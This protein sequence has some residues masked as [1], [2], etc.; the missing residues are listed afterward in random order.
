M[1]IKKD[2][3]YIDLANNLA[4][5][6]LGY[7][8]PNPSV[9]A[10]I[11][12]NNKVLSFGSTNFSGRP[13][14]E[15]NALNKLTFKDKKNSTI[16]IS[17]EPCSHFGKTPPCVNEL[18]NSKVKKVVYSAEDVDER[19]SG[20]AYKILKSSKIEV[21]KNILNN[22]SK[23]IYKNYFYSKIN[24][25][26]VVY[27]K[28]AISKDFY[29]K[30]LNKKYITNELSLR[31]THILRSKVNCILST[32]KTIND[33]NPKLDC[34]IDGLK[35][36]SPQVAILDKNLKININSYIVKNAK[37]NRTYLFY[38]KID[39]NKIKLLKSKKIILIYTPLHNNKLNFSFILKKLFKYE[40]SSLLVEGGKTLTLSLLKDNLFKEFYL[41]ISP[42]SLNKT[43]SI[44]INGIKSKL[45]K[46]FKKIKYNEIFLDKDNLIHYY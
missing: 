38:N 21:K 22:I 14:A 3:Y 6:Y 25:I 45:S 28:L 35:N 39:K 12:K 9:G 31:T 43:G 24:Q 17:L 30:N 26:P 37:F 7:S 19:T 4:K 40:I 29:T 34:R 10:I 2:K 16:Y 23:D 44:K 32:S 42:Q 20:K 15:V 1:S 18:I 46:K 27:G 8:G 13:H 11:V 5:N 36:S 41:F 33:D